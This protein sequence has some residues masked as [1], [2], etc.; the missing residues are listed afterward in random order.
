MPRN[1]RIA[2][3]A[4]AGKHGPTVAANRQRMAGLIEQAMAEK[5]D[6]I[7]IPE[8]FTIAGLVDPRIEEMAEE[9][10]GPTLE[11]AADYARKH[12]THG[13]REQWA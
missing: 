9:V 8:S 5:P 6:I 2:T 13:E 7:A 4:L 10:P 12:S 11:M 1:V 3:I